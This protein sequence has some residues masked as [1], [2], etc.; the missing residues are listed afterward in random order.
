MLADGFIDWACFAFQGLASLSTSTTAN[1]TRPPSVEHLCLVSCKN[2]HHVNA[3]RFGE[4]KRGDVVAFVE[5][6]TVLIAAL[7]AILQAYMEDYKRQLPKGND[8]ELVRSRFASKPT[9]G[10]LKSLT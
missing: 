2:R 5:V 1:S 10:T 7:P 6:A 4:W 9:T 3:S 8:F